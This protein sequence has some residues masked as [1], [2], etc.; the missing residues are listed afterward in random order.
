[1]RLISGGRVQLTSTELRK[2]GKPNS[3][4][5]VCLVI[6]ILGNQ[7]HISPFRE[8]IFVDK[9]FWKFTSVQGVSKKLETLPIIII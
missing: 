5:A 6:R 1:M 4:E 7:K 3:R 8:L 9:C 2:S